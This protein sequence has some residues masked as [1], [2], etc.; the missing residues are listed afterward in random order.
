MP[1]P[2]PSVPNAQKYIRLYGGEPQDDVVTITEENPPLLCELE[3]L[4]T[5]IFQ[6]LVHCLMIYKCYLNQLTPSLDLSR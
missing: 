2:Q 4:S 1:L 5:G 6:P 3:R